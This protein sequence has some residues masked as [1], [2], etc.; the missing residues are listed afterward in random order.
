MGILVDYHDHLVGME[1]LCASCVKVKM[2]LIELK[3]VLK[4]GWIDCGGISWGI[5]TIIAWDCG[6]LVI[7]VDLVVILV[8]SNCETHW[9]WHTKGNAL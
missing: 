3:I 4:I 7:C 9:V 6:A 8:A 1:E 2:V 5:V